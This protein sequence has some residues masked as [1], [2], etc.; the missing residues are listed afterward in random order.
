MKR[1]LAAVLLVSALSACSGG[2]TPLAPARAASDLTPADRAALRDGGTLRWA[3]DRVPAA[4]DVYAADATADTALLAHAVLPSLYRLDERA[5]PVADPDFLAGADRADRTVTYRLNPRA[6]WSDGTPLSAAD[7]TAQWTALRTGQPGYAAIESVAQ[8]AD[9]HQVK[10]VFRQAY[11]EWQELFSPLYPAAGAQALLPGAAGAGLSAGPLAVRS[12]DAGAGRASLVRNPHWWGEP[13]KLDGIDFRVTPDRLDALEHGQLDVA[14]LE[15][16]V[17]HPPAA[18]SA[19]AVDSSVQALKRAEALPGVTLHRAPAPAFT[20]LT[21]NGARGPLADAAVRRAVA[22]AV[23]R[24]GLATA[25]LAPLGLPATALGNHLLMA[26]QDGYRDNSAALGATA[27][28]LHLDLSLLYPDDSATARRTADALTAQLAPRGVTV[29]AQAVPAAGFVHD[30]LAVG[31]FDLALFSWPAAAFPAVDERALYAKPRPGAD[32][33]PVAG[34]NYAGSGTDEIDQLF[35]RAAAEPDRA[36]QTALLQQADTR[37]WE[38]GHSVPLFQ[39]P[40]LVAVRAGV[41]GAGAYGFG[42]PRYQ[43]LGFHR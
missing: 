16:T 8:G 27:K 21:L 6:Q 7:F 24:G 43:D 42:W 12:L 14:A 29:K 20:Q 37:L 18:K 22:A 5:R 41:A 13:A 40:E 9:P 26:D 32:G 25:A 35:D 28:D 1:L 15:G 39:R 19:D 33:R 11:P 4:L 34:L 36:R 2:P 31:D 3:V 17:D 38:L 30:H 10:V 23:D